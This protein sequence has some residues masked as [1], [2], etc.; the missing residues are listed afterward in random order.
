MLRY[1]GQLANSPMVLL[2]VI[3]ILFAFFT[4]LAIIAQIDL[5]KAHPVAC[6]AYVT[7]A[8]SSTLLLH[9]PVSLR[10]WVGILLITLGAYVASEHH[11]SK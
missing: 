8:L 1:T 5:S 9:E 10:Q 3:C 2:G 11:H 4:W 7:V 6:L